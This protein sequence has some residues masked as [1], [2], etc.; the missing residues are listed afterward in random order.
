[1]EI[2]YEELRQRWESVAKTPQVLT[3]GPPNWLVKEQTRKGES[4]MEAFQRIW[5]EYRDAYR[6][7][8]TKPVTRPKETRNTDEKPVT[9]RNTKPVTDEKPVTLNFGVRGPK[10][11]YQSSAEKQRAYRERRHGQ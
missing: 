3:S 1:M 8:V 9:T 5:D 4:H 7:L 2:D 11:T 10:P 6:K